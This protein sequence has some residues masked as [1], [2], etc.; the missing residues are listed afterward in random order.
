VFFSIHCVVA[1]GGGGKT[2]RVTLFGGAP[3]G[4]VG[5]APQQQRRRGSV[6]ASHS[7]QEE[8][9]HTETCATLRVRVVR[10]REG[11]GVDGFVEWGRRG[12]MMMVLEEGKERKTHHE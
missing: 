5:S 6:P 3:A 8:R 2:R 10:G 9:A 7:V 12:W 4:F 11:G 1:G